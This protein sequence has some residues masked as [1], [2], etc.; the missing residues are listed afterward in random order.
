MVEAFELSLGPVETAGTETNQWLRLHGEKVGGQ[1]LTVWLLCDRY[2]SALLAEA[3]A[4]VKQYVLQEGSSEPVEFQDGA[5]GRAL[6][7]MLGAWPYLL[8]RFADGAAFGSGFAPS[9]VLLGHSFR[10]SETTDVTPSTPPSGRV[11]KLRSDALVGLPHNTRTV[12]SIRR[13]DGSDYPLVRL[14]TQDY[15]AMIEAGMNCFNADAEQRS[16]IETRGV[17]YW[18]GALGNLPYP[19]ILYRSSYLGPAL[20]LDEPAVGTRDYVIRP[21]LKQEPELARTLSPQTV[22][23][24]FEEY[25]HKAKYEGPAA[26][27]MRSL[28]ARPDV[29]VGE[30]KFLQENLFTWE[31]MI[32]TGIQQLTE[33]TN[34]PPSAIVFEPP[35]HVGTRRTLPEMDMVYGCQIP[36]DDPVNLTGV[37]YGFLRGAARLSG[38]DWGTSIYGA[39]D[40]ADSPWFLNRAFDLGARFFFFWDTSAS[41]C[42][43]FEECL[44]LS[45]G[46]QAH[47]ES[48][49]KRDLVRL[50]TAAEVLILLPPGYNLGHV[51]LGKGSLW[52]L[53]E[54]NLERTNRF[55]VTYRQVMSN[56]FQEIERCV[57]AGVA[58]DLVWDV[59]GLNLTGYREVVHVFEDGRVRMDG[60]DG[61]IRAA[62]SLPRP[63]GVPPHLTLDVSTDAT[64]QATSLVARAEVREG[65]S[66]IFYTARPSRRGVYDNA[67]VLWELFGPRS[68]DYRALLS[69]G[70]V[71]QITHDGSTWRITVS[72][73]L[74]RAG[75]YRLRAA[76]V[77][78]A[79][80]SAVAW[81]TVT[82]H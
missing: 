26:E 30:M 60:P 1:S 10:L 29:A 35:G 42:V 11:L 55:G 38:R 16:W 69:D 32:S 27:L 48:C 6:L 50:K 40:R 37:L 14:T 7:P 28:S 49:P 25:F 12:D 73:T 34:G 21:Q 39:V 61:L 43:P 20:F 59:P 63:D 67:L 56:F 65:S 58:Y 24:A 82:V 45:K 62:P 8:P 53:G 15:D 46:L 19:E 41:A 75:T 57:R 68:E 2:P 22:L 74:D 23:A 33:G 77:D 81:A 18:G 54:L 70:V 80:R 9:A 78:R 47:I 72:T 44:A 76:T 36:T 3:Q 31:T 13:F 79:G 17:F 71:P 66:P 4:H 52:G 64:G 5:T 51:H